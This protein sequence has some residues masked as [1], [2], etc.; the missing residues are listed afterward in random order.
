[1]STIHDVAHLAGVS[2]KT[3]SR[4]VNRESGIRPATL[5]RVTQAIEKLSY[6]PHRGARM[7]RSAKSG[8]VGIVTAR[9]SLSGGPNDDIGLSDMH[10]LRGAHRVCREAGMTLLMADAAGDPNAVADLLDTF[11]SHQVEGVI[12]VAPSHQLVPMLL[13]SDV[14]LVLANCFD[15]LGTTSVLPDDALG[16]RLAVERLVA[17]GHRRIGYV[18][19]PE[20]NVAGRLRKAAFIETCQ[21]QGLSP[22]DCPALIGATAD[23]P[24]T[25]APLAAALADLVARPQ[26]PTALCLGN[27][28]MA[29]HAIRCLEQLGLR[30][31]Q[32][33]ALIGYDNDSTLCNA[34]RPRLSTITLPYEAMGA[35][36][37]EL[38]LERLAQ[39]DQP[40]QT[41]LV[42]CEVVLRDSCP[43]LN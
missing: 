9:L 26:R 43:A 32:D 37:A 28:I 10:L 2:I 29:L 19:L 7:M 5:E 22:A 8:L 41:C 21:A 11:A 20:T 39:P 30:L 34:L 6:R 1:M 27:D 36:A 15:L 17:L 33:M 25:F 16:Q 38:L 13:K 42:P 40:A 31:P 4:V 3:V 12:F 14:P 23:G 18:G 24:N 35:R